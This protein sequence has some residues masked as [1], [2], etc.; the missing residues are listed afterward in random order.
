MSVLAFLKRLPLFLR[1]K[2]KCIHLNQINDV[3]PSTQ[4]CEECLKLGDEWVH[5]RMCLICGHVGCCDNSKN[6]HASA[7]YYQT[8][9]PIIQSIEPGESWRWCYVDQMLIE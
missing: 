2:G 8:W 4:G 9:H 1:R 3:I 6:K 5:L 7:H